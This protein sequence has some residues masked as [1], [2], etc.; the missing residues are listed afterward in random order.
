MSVAVDA[1]PTHHGTDALGIVPVKPRLHI[2][3]RAFALCRRPIDQSSP[4]PVGKLRQGQHTVPLYVRCASGNATNDT[5]FLQSEAIKS[6]RKERL[7]TLLTD[8]AAIVG[9]KKSATSRDGTFMSEVAQIGG[10]QPIPVKVEEGKRYWWCACGLSKAQPFCDGS[11][12]TT[13]FVP[14]EFRPTASAEVWFCACKRSSRK[15]MCD[16]SH[17][18]L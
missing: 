5:A 17:Q 9:L 7:A 16:G 12:K 18:K 11:H 6:G 15:P 1:S 8:L 10:R 14:V 13:T 3:L 4:Q 2:K